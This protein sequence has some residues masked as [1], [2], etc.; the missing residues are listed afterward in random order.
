MPAL[1]G[2]HS[3]NNLP[4]S[5]TPYLHAQLVHLVVESGL[6]E[7]SRR[8]GELNQ[9][10]TII[11]LVG[12]PQLNRDHDNILRRAQSGAIHVGSPFGTE[13][14]LLDPTT[15]PGDRREHSISGARGKGAPV[16]VTTNQPVTLGTVSM[17]GKHRIPERSRRQ[18]R[19][20]RDFTRAGAALVKYSQQAR[21]RTPNCHLT[22]S[23]IRSK[24]SIII[25]NISINARIF[26][27]L[28][29]LSRF[30]S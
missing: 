11:R 21:N 22:P 29:G 16:Q 9:V 19:F 23:A 6:I 25:P 24:E 15:D 4:I 26:L 3:S 17:S 20:E 30:F 18:P 2:V 27:K 28:D 12:N 8:L 10:E 1:A 13:L 14:T 7:R 5:D